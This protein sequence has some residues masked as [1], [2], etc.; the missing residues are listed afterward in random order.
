[1]VVSVRAYAAMQPAMLAYADSRNWV[2]LHDQD[3][4]SLV[5]RACSAAA[6]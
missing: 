2:L 6:A 5:C 3:L 1:M 4:V